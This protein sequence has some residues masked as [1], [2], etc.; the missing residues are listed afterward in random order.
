MKAALV[1]LAALG[2][3]SAHKRHEQFH[4]RGDWGVKPSGWTPDY[5]QSECCKEVVTVTVYG[6]ST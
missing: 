5:F 6:S 1:L 2:L 3:A 4:R